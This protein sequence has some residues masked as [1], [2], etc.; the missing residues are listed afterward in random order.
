MALFKDHY[1][2]LD[3]KRTPKVALQN[4]VA[5]ETGNRLIITLTNGDDPI[6]LDT[7]NYRVALRV[8][9]A[10]GVR[11]QD[12]AAANNGITY[13]DGKAIILLSKDSYT[14]NLN[15]A[16]L[17][18]YTTAS[19]EDDTLVV[20]AEFMFY[21]KGMD[22]GENVGTAIPVM[23]QYEHLAEYWASQAKAIAL[24][25][26][27]IT[28]TE[29]GT[30]AVTELKLSDALKLKTIKDYVTPEMFGAVG[31]GVTDDTTAW[32]AAVD[33]GMDVRATKSA[34]KVGQINVT[35]NVSIYCNSARFVCT[36]TKLFNCTGE[37]VTTLQ[38]EA[39]YAI[40][41]S[42]YAI[43]NASYATYT[44]F[45]MLKGTNNFEKTKNY[46]RGGFA[47]YFKNGK[48]TARY[49]IN[50]TGVSI[51]IINPITVY[52]YNIGDIEH[53]VSTRDFSII[54]K[55]GYGCA[56]RDSKIE[57]SGAYTVIQLDSC[58]NC[59]VDNVNITQQFSSNDNNSYL[60]NIDNASFCT[61]RDC[62]M[63]NKNWH[64]ITTG[65]TYLCYG[66]S[67]DN[68]HLM[69][70]GQLAIQDHLNARGTK[71]INST[72]SCIGISGMGVIENC[73]IEPIAV[74]PYNCVVYLFAVSDLD[75]ATYRVANVSV[76]RKTDASNS[77]TGVIIGGGVAN[78]ESYYIKDVVF[79][80]VKTVNND[81][82]GTF[83]FGF[84]S[85]ASVVIK[86][87]HI[88]DCTL[89]IEMGKKS[90][91]TG[92]NITAYSLFLS[93]IESISTSTYYPTFGT[94]SL[95]YND[96]YM[97]NVKLNSVSGA[98]A[99]L[100]LNGFWARNGLSSSATVTTELY[101]SAIN[102]EIRKEVLLS[103]SRLR[104]SDMRGAS[105]VQYFN[106]VRGTDNKRYWSYIDAN[107]AIA[108]AEI[109]V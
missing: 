21:A 74:S 61:V 52:I 62:Y 54:I 26:G 101:G 23:I 68:C 33:T 13:D 39:D 4:I 1:I 15:R 81:K 64:C 84:A 105:Y 49:P 20:S 82:S 5:G 46:Y 47:C 78:N 45:A 18:V 71:I 27:C 70:E 106:I 80:N 38:D 89:N 48:M 3:L 16:V 8:T 50:V 36:A 93:N 88:N 65:D 98:F 6:A 51:E 107:G 94:T 40:N 11:R 32:Q 10:L 109:T 28:A 75:T 14:A 41:Q 60:V 29:L 24:P 83:M 87:I 85:G 9:S 57:H 42:D 86:N 91:N 30:G 31:D 58:L 7:T 55:Y 59:I 95:T 90:T 44:G 96:V 73:V 19:D 103:A 35:R 99:N 34:Y 77:Y 69:S 17:E 108:T 66:N 67:V 79:D 43:T 100:Y 12:S 72:C 37:V 92:Y 63:F 97:S 25:A 102:S 22:E 56:I 53:N 104:V 2:T 76:N